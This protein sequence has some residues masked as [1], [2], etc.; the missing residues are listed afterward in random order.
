M[1]AL[2][3]ASLEMTVAVVHLGGYSYDSLDFLW[4]R[5]H[6]FLAEYDAIECDFGGFYLTLSAIQGY[7]HWLHALSWGGWHS[8]LSLSSHVPLSHCGCTECWGI[9]TI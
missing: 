7:C 6:A 5:L 4:I 8:V 2:G 9:S 3:L 1:A